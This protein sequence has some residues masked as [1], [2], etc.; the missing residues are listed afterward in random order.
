[1]IVPRW[2][3]QRRQPEECV[4]PAGAERGGG[5]EREEREAV[6]A[7][8][9]VDVRAGA[10]PV[11][12]RRVSARLGLSPFRRSSPLV[13]R[14]D[15]IAASLVGL[16]S[17]RHDA[18]PCYGFIGVADST[19]YIQPVSFLMFQMSFYFVSASFIFKNLDSTMV[20]K[21]RLEDKMCRTCT[22]QFLKLTSYA[23]F[24]DFARCW[25]WLEYF[26]FYF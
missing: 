11:S 26:F 16:G 19:Y 8:L 2:R 17:A 20:L 14:S 12:A 23:F 18:T 1:M 15:P 22:D 7:A 10:R 25:Y 4:A 6:R 9:R 13:V 24:N 3:Y 5:K 21:F